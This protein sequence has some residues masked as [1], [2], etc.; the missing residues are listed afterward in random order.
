MVAIWDSLAFHLVSEIVDPAGRFLIL[1]CDINSTR[2][3]L[4]NLY[5]PNYHQLYFLHKLM[6]RLK[7]VKQGSLLL[8]G[9]FNILRD[10]QMD[11][12]FLQKGTTASLQILLHSQNLFDVC[13]WIHTSE[14]DY[15]YFSAAHFYLRIDLFLADKW[16]L[17]R[18]QDAAVRPCPYNHSNSR[19]SCSTTNFS[20]EN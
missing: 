5:A 15:S 2:Y 6:K 14:R 3:T 4:I 18:I 17:Q 13:R 8:C 10:P 16:L 19:L 7:K 20:M 9:D 11:S 12:T 1:I